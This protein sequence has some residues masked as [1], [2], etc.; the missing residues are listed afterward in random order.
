MNRHRLDVFALG[1]GIFFVALAIGFL[2][3]GL[4]IWDMDGVWAAPAVLIAFG[5]AGM[6]SVISRPATA[7]PEAP[8]VE[9]AVEPADSHADS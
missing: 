9:P 6:L 1:T 8:A 5:L 2:L 3:D 7:I 4:E